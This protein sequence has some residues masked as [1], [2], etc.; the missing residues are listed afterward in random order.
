MDISVLH[1]AIKSI[2]FK[3]NN[4]IIKNDQS[5]SA[6]KIEDGVEVRISN[7]KTKLRTWLNNNKQN[8]IPQVCISIVC[9]CDDELDKIPNDTKLPDN[10]DFAVQ[11]FIYDIRTFTKEDMKA[12]VDNINATFLNKSYPNNALP[13]GQHPSPEYVTKT[14][15]KL[16][17]KLAKKVKRRGGTIVHE[18]FSFHIPTFE[19][20]AQVYETKKALVGVSFC[21]ENGVKRNTS[22]DL[23]EY[24]QKPWAE[25]FHY[26]DIDDGKYVW[27]GAQQK[28][29]VKGLEQYGEMR[30]TQWFVHENGTIV[31]FRNPKTHDYI[32]AETDTK[33]EPLFKSDDRVSQWKLTWRKLD[34]IP[35]W[36]LKH[37][38]ILEFEGGADIDNL[39]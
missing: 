37:F 30:E 33:L 27:D 14:D 3:T 29:L 8:G 34:V 15:S 18:S 31:P 20:F 2:G 12:L 35:E 26:E 11:Q 25:R 36:V 5:Y 7:H 23:P 21:D 1:E 28:Y 10:V 17:D 13:N 4:N 24:F 32:F 6:Y 19:E 9:K 16:I 22:D 39:D 38:S